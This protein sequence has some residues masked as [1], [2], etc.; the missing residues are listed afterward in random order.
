MKCRG[1][2]SAQKYESWITV[3]F[4]PSGIDYFLPGPKVTVIHDSF[5]A[6]IP[7]LNFKVD[8][9]CEIDEVAC[10]MCGSM[11]G[12]GWEGSDCTACV[13]RL[14]VLLRILN[15]AASLIKVA[16]KYPGHPGIT[17]PHISSSLVA[18]S[19]EFPE[20]RDWWSIGPYKTRIQAQI[21]DCI[22]CMP[23]W[24]ISSLKLNAPSLLPYFLP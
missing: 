21:L 24:L 23:W 20:H 2:M 22:S 12:F 9:G 16:E 1:G 4:C 10:C 15:P 14:L 17:K 6:L 19:K 3:T 5:W 18:I 8:W 13:L 11:L 7:S